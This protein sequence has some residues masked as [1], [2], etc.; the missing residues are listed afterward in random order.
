MAHSVPFLFNGVD[1]PDSRHLGRC[2]GGAS[3][4][5]RRG[6]EW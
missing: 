3:L 4:K 6:G 5:R 1:E 2:A